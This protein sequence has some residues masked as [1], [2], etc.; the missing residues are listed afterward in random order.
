M[1]TL[2][3]FDFYCNHS[4]D[5]FFMFSKF[6]SILY[7]DHLVLLSKWGFNYCIRDTLKRAREWEEERK[8]G[9]S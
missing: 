2:A 1:N 5:S 6:Y 8:T 7:L 9:E 3:R 4:S